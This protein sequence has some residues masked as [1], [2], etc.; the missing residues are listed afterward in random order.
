[1]VEKNTA[2]SPADSLQSLRGKLGTSDIPEFWKCR[3]DRTGNGLHNALHTISQ[4]ISSFGAEKVRS[5]NKRRWERLHTERILLEVGFHVGVA[6][7][8]GYYWLELRE[9]IVKVIEP[10]V[11]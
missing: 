1:M 6:H 7:S 11:K 3:N 10:H 2:Q 9:K 4:I 5:G 8:Q